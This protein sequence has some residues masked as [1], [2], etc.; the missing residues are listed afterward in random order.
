VFHDRLA[1]TTER[2]NLGPGGTEAD[3]DSYAPMVSIDNDRR[4]YS[5]A[6][7]LVPGDTNNFRRLR[8]RSRADELRDRV[9][10]GQNGVIACR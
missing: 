2:V 6:T 1:G 9:P 3:G 10:P 7:T 5:H 4:L 8:P